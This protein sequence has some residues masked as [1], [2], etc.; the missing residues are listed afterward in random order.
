VRGTV[1][2]AFRVPSVAELYQGRGDAFPNVADPCSSV[3]GNL[4]NATV[5]AN[6]AAD[7]YDGGV[8]DDRTQLLTRVGGSPELEPETADT[9][10]LGLVL[11][12][13]LVPGLT[14]SIDYYR[15][16]IDNAIQATGA[17]TILA[18][19]YQQAAGNRRFCDQIQR[20]G[21]GFIQNITDLNANV[22]GFRAEGVDL[23]LRYRS[24]GFGFG[25]LSAGI[26]GTLLLDLTQIQA[27]GFEQSF[28]GNYDQAAG[29]AP[30]ANPRYRLSAF[31]RWALSPFNAGVNFRYL[32]SFDECEGGPCN[33]D[34]VEP[35]I[36]RAI[37]DYYYMDVF[38]GIDLVYPFGSTSFT[39]GINNVTDATPPYIA[40]GF[41]AESDAATYDYAGRSFYLR[42]TQRF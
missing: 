25:R 17:G 27:D 28:V 15:I 6:C 7:G 32:P 26:D 14:A 2:T 22:G 23:G 37:D 5:A 42:L 39:V 9:F 29:A 11:E 13:Q 16:A 34:S 35:P 10:T 41:L 21:A 31:L 1:S 36:Q 38:A 24:P 20:D 19:C 12:D 33:V 3:R 18:S 8:P 40:N 4:N 30:G